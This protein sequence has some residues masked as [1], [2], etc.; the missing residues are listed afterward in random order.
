VELP[1]GAISDDTQLR[2]ATSRSILPDGTFDV[3]AF[4]KIELTVW[5]A[6]AIGAGRGSKA[7][8]SH[9][10][11]RDTTWASNFFERGVNYVHGGGNG[12]AMRIQ[13][14]VWAAGGRAMH[15]VLHSVLVN[16]ICTHGHPRGF[17]GALF[18][19]RCLHLVLAQH[20]PCEPED[21]L[22]IVDEFGYAAEL[23]RADD[24]VR[25]L[26]LQPWEERSGV[27]LDAAIADVA[28]EMRDDIARITELRPAG[29]LGA[30]RTAVEELKLFSSEQR[31]SGTKTALLAAMASWIFAADAHAGVLAC[32][33]ALGT[34]TD[35]VATMAGA[36]LGVLADDE[37]DDPIQDAD[38]VRHEADRM[39]AI[40]E[41]RPVPSFPFVDLLSWMPPRTQSDVVGTQG[42]ALSVAGLGPCVE[43]GQAWLSGGRE[44]VL[45]GWLRL[46]FG[47][48]IMAK[49]RMKAAEL[50][51][52]A[53]VIPNADYVTAL[54]EPPDRLSLHPEPRALDSGGTHADPR[55]VLR[56]RGRSP[57]GREQGPAGA[58]VAPTPE[59][60]ANGQSAG[61]GGEVQAAV[62]AA[63]SL[64]EL[65]DVVIRSGFDP[66]IVGVALLK[67]IDG[68]EAGIERA[69]AYSAIIAKARMSRRA[70]RGS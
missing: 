63:Q 48:H 2:L 59:P 70:S 37:P 55:G 52:E 26:W 3:E 8:A 21:W 45:Y 40:A 64:H 39:W 15:T 43:V 7:A 53:V 19:A 23:L 57:D 20:R 16:A 62:E 13:P 22:A 5:P 50:P 44:P 18:H 69:G 4:S 61:R 66:E 24:T 25:D 17:M 32:A 6:Y 67:A 10:S 51:R 30:L 47:Q 65:T 60:T 33:N 49:R 14:H 34:D 58:V 31:G 46:W 35:T 42:A 27:S 36:L 12:A 1:A 29:G 68:T 28:R 54:P 11:R 41:G 38:Y 56:P 9:L